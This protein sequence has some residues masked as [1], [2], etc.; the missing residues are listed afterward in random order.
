MLQRRI[1]HQP[2]TSASELIPR[3]GAQLPAI[4]REALCR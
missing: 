2:F 4:S 1:R 3:R